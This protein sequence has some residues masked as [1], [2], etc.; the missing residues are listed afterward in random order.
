MKQMLVEQ[1]SACYDE[2]TWFVALKNALDG[3]TAEQAAWKADGVDN[4]IWECVSHLNFYNFAYLERFKGVHYVYPTDDNDATFETP[5]GAGDEAWA[6]AVARLD[7]ILKEFREL[8]KNADDSKFDQPVSAVN[9]AK[10][11][12]LIA[13]INAH[14]AYHGGQILL[15][16]K[17]QGKWDQAKGVS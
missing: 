10:W 1:F 15:L 4:S 13:N 9:H 3:V 2:N 16:R 11:S 7:A 12:T 17:L 6:V 5:E 8:L 14:N